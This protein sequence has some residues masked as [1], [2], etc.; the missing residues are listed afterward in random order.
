VST[1]APQALFLMN[2]PFVLEQARHAARRL[3]SG[4]WNN[5][6]ARLTRAYRAT[7]GRPPTEGERRLAV[8]FLSR[9]NVER[10]EQAWAQLFQMLIASVD[11]RYVE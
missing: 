10:P 9:T 2:H 7:L 6:R 11:F 1:S 8:A 3:L 5:D 4:P